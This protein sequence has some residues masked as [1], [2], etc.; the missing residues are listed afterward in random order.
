MNQY[1][2]WKN[3]LVLSIVVIGAVFALPNLYDDDFAIQISSRGHG[4]IGLDLMAQVEIMLNNKKIKYKQVKLSDNRLLIR[5]FDVDMQLKAKEAFDDTIR[6]GYIIALNLASTIPEWLDRIG[7][8]SINLGLDLRGGVYFLVDV[9]MDTVVRKSLDTYSSELRVFLRNEK[10]RYKE[11]RIVNDSLIINLR[12]AEDLNMVLSTAKIEFNQLVMYEVKDSMVPIIIIKLT[13]V[14]LRKIQLLALEQ[15]IVTLRNRIR[16]LGVT[17]PIV[18]RQGDRRIVVQ[19]PGVQDT[20]RAKKILSATATLE[21]RLVD[22]NYNVQNAINGRVSSELVN[23]KLFNHRDGRQFFL[24]ERVILTGEHII[25]AASMLDNQSG[26]PS[27]SITLDSKGARKFSN[28]TVDNIG[29]AMAVVFIES[30][31]SI[32]EINSEMIKVS[33]QVPEIISVAII[34]DQLSKK[35]QITGLDSTAEAYELALLLRAGSLAVPIE[36]IEERTIG[37]SLG[38]DNINQGLKAIMLGFIIVLIFM[39]IW[40]QVF[41]AVANLALAVNLVLIVAL[42]SIFQATLTMPGIAGIVLTIG[43]A[44]DANILIFE[45]I[46]EELCTGNTSQVCIS[47]GYSKAFSTIADANVTTLI[48]AIILFSFGTGLVKGFAVTLS[49][50]ILT[51]MFTAIMGTRVIINYIY[52]NKHQPKLSI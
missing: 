3:M 42:L 13:E 7:G 51:S 43:M 16:E 17:E 6:D 32:H 2:L 30:K 34:R 48:V 50:G 1:P 5:F 9:D 18:Q 29:N 44:V 35:F 19:L 14:F 8:E 12:N 45:R 38:Q 11:M 46:R 21:F 52:G 10:I 49:L 37:P 23:V 27:V 39:A 25:N 28:A 33:R 26:L 36:I 24:N 4:K 22:N 31:T 41:G 40:Y 20:A 47:F 15:N